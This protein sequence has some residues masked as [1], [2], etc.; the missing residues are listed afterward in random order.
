MEWFIPHKA[1]KD[2]H[3][4]SLFFLCLHSKVL[5]LLPYSPLFHTSPFGILS[6][7]SSS[8]SLLIIHTDL[9]PA[10]P[11][12]GD[13]S[14]KHLYLRQASIFNSIIYIYIYTSSLIDKKKLGKLELSMPATTIS[15][16]D[17]SFTSSLI[18]E[19]VS[20]FFNFPLLL[21]LDN[22]QGFPSSV[23]A[24][25]LPFQIWDSLQVSSYS[26]KNHGN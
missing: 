3:H 12:F 14:F 4:Q 13:D 2:F 1:L 9:V 19:G 17:S 16:C 18:V 22:I 20:L 6:P 21:V 26:M 5:L 10:L 7:Y 11:M 8:S 15:L 23:T 24:D 25:Y